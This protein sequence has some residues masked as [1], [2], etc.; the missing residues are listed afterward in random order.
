MLHAL[1]ADPELYLINASPHDVNH[2]LLA[3]TRCSV[4]DTALI[5]WV[6]ECALRRWQDPAG[7][8]S[9]IDVSGIVH[10]LGKLEMCPPKHAARLESCIATVVHQLHGRALATMVWGVARLAPVVEWDLAL[11]GDLLKKNRVR[12][13]SRGIINEGHHAAACLSCPTH[14]YTHTVENDPQGM[15][16]V[17]PQH[18]ANVAWA[19]ATLRHS[20]SPKA[21]AAALAGVQPMLGDCKPKELCIILWSC[22]LHNV[23][24]AAMPSGRRAS[25]AGASSPPGQPQH[26]AQQA[27][28]AHV[29]QVLS[30]AWSRFCADSAEFNEQ[31]VSLLLWSQTRLRHGVLQEVDWPR[32]AAW[33]LAHVESMEPRHLGMVAWATSRLPSAV[34]EAATL[35]Q[36]LEQPT[37]RTLHDFTPMDLA[38][39]VHACGKV[40][41]FPSP[42]TLD[43]LAQHVTA[44]FD[45]FLIEEL[46]N[47]LWGF[48]AL[49]HHPGPLVGLVAAKVGVAA[50]F[51]SSVRIYHLLW[52]AQV[53]QEPVQGWQQKTLTWCFSVFGY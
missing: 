30:T 36:A 15:S 27:S 5:D 47:V 9:P 48:A 4:H 52:H 6:L 17:K 51:D 31:D 10:S 22:A 37:L 32:M 20:R 38:N 16:F 18:A 23:G 46:T 50:L 1:A 2:V 53:Q 39:F 25:S 11:V 28:Q 35:F 33:L 19:A 40:R 13:S 49:N 43:K 12:A 42:A 34:D 7:G 3:C 21:V 8:V 45:S 26:D 41:Y 14:I 29:V 44:R 24:R